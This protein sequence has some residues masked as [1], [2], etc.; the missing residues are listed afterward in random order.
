MSDV[1]GADSEQ[2]ISIHRGGTGM[3]AS[4]GAYLR[5]SLQATSSRSVGLGGN[6]WTCGMLSRRCACTLASPGRVA[7]ALDVVQI[8]AVCSSYLRG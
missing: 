5:L 1:V 4:A 8:N 3:S 7:D 2:A 6:L